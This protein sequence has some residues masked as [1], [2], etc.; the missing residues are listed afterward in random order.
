MNSKL[1][2][3]AY[4]KSEADARVELSVP[5]IMAF[6]PVT[7]EQ[8]GFPT[9]VT[10]EKELVRYVDHN[11]E[12][13]V[14]HLYDSNRVFPPIGYSNKFTTDEFKLINHI[15]DIVAEMTQREFDRVSVW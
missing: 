11:F 13:E 9:V 7:Y 12:A 2:V 10:S 4:D 15:R 1:S 8:V 6:R 3:S 5:L 14:P